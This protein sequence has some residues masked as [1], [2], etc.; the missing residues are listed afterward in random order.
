MHNLEIE[1]DP[2]I[3]INN[4]MG[5]GL[6]VYNWGLHKISQLQKKGVQKSQLIFDPGI[7]FGK[8]AQQNVNILKNIDIFHDLGL[9]IYVGHSKK[10]FLSEMFKKIDDKSL[11]TAAVSAFLAK[12]GVDYIR[13]HDVALNKKFLLHP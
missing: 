10:R 7:G 4:G 8:N 3:I 13:V 5:A 11:K 2:N 1:I 6:K 12:R 9:P